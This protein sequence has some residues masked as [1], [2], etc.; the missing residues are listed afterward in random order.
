M[1]KIFF[2]TLILCLLNA[3]L[4]AQDN[5]A[6]DVTFNIEVQKV[7]V[8]KGLIYVSVYTNETEYKNKTAHYL[9]K[10]DSTKETVLNE[11]TL[12]AGSYLIAT[13]Q[14]IN[15]NGK[16]DMR[17]LVPQ[18]PIGM[19]NYFGGI[20]GGYKKLTVKVDSSTKKVTIQQISF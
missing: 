7:I 14:D 11:V 8:G 20:P 19:T 4:F 17:L 3:A 15:G 9:F 5:S 10:F 6:E 18:E 12:P 13:F 16:L 2:G 1:K